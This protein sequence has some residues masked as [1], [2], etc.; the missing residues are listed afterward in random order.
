M[1]PS[2]VK[3]A[4][5]WPDIVRRFIVL[6]KRR[7]WDK[8]SKKTASSRQTEKPIR[9][10]PVTIRT[11][12]QFLLSLSTQ[13]MRA[14]AGDTRSAWTIARYYAEA[15]RW[16]K[17]DPEN[18]AIA[19]FLGRVSGYMAEAR[20]RYSADKRRDVGAALLVR[21]N[22]G[23]PGR[24]SGDRRYTDDQVAE[25]AQMAI[26]TWREGKAEKFAVSIACEKT[27]VDQRTIR[28]AIKARR[29]FIPEYK[30]LLRGIR[31]PD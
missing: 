20:R 31:S 23:N 7:R 26:D 12:A 14:N 13:L 30:G 5:L 24:Q 19:E 22:R 25:A 1:R 3:D 27:G 2:A 9:T 10:V 8:R 16:R 4:S 15:L 29:D 6:E 18:P 11:F 28:Q 21:K 17:R